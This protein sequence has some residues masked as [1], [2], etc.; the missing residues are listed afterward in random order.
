MATAVT[1]RTGEGSRALRT[2]IV[3]DVHPV[4]VV[5]PGRLELLTG[6]LLHGQQCACSFWAE[7]LGTTGD[8]FIV[9]VAQVVQQREIGV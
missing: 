9:P 1:Y 5:A 6:K 7:K 8:D 2:V 3:T 4:V